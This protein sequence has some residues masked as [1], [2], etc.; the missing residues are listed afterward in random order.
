MESKAREADQ[1]PPWLQSLRE[2]IERLSGR[3][4]ALEAAAQA[5]VPAAAAPPA[6]A[7]LSP[8]LVAVIGAAVAAFLGKKAHL[9]QV[10]LVGG[11]SW[12]QHGRATIQASHVLN[13][14]HD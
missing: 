4:A 1:V 3:V 13:V 14:R 11:S 10:R 5:P 7:E 9:R 8:Q 6:S 12:A 2:E